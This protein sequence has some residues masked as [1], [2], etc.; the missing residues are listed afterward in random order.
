M[1]LFL[2]Y[3]SS[4]KR[5][6]WK[7]DIARSCIDSRHVTEREVLAGHAEN[8]MIA[9]IWGEYRGKGWRCNMLEGTLEDME[10]EGAYFLI[11]VVPDLGRVA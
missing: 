8:R 2:R 11:Q 9:W 1:L 7:P 3:L 6:A 5:A 4:I 10:R